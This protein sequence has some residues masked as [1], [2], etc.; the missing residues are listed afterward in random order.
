MT[1]ILP[2]GD[3]KVF[4]LSFSSHCV[5]QRLHASSNSERFFTARIRIFLP[6]RR[7]KR[8]VRREKNSANDFHLLSPTFAAFASLRPRSGHALRETFRFFWLELS[9]LGSLRL[10]PFLSFPLVLGCRTR[11]T[12]KSPCQY[13]RCHQPLPC[14]NPPRL[15]RARP[16]GDGSLKNSFHHKENHYGY[17]S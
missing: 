10:S 12:G 17:L 13:S 11:I 15:A 14:Y 7:Q 9:A 8:Q 4:I 6:P 1:I 5:S 16:R 2:V 3:E